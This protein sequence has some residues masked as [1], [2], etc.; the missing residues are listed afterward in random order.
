MWGVE[1]GVK[2]GGEAGDKSK[3]GKEEVRRREEGERGEERRGGEA[4]G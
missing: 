1:V 4:G 2:E 3:G